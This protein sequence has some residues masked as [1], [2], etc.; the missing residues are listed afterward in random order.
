MAVPSSGSG[1][2][3]LLA[4]LVVCGAVAGLVLV[5]AS[6]AHAKNAKI[7]TERAHVSMALAAH[8]WTQAGLDKLPQRYDRARFEKAVGGEDD[9]YNIVAAIAVA[10]LNANPGRE[11][12]VFKYLN[13]ALLPFALA[14]KPQYVCLVAEVFYNSQ[15]S[16]SE[17]Q[18]QTKAGPSD[19]GVAIA[20]IDYAYFLIKTEPQREKLKLTAPANSGIPESMAAFK[21]TLTPK[22]GALIPD[23]AISLDCDHQPNS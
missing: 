22:G 1:R 8:Y 14:H 9:P 13:E 16:T 12:A 15:S 20:F 5:Q 18:A 21:K 6:P 3:R 23:T 17:L 11:D 4:L 7:D 2:R 19:A 10:T